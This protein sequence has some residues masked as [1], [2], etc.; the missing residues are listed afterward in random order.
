M[1]ALVP[2]GA[3]C[4][5]DPDLQ[6]RHGDRRNGNIVAVVDRFTQRLTPALGID[7]DRGVKD[8]SCQ[9][10]VTGSMP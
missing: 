8:Q 10:S 3:L 6:L 4:Q 7:Q 1:L 9:G 2:Y 5:L